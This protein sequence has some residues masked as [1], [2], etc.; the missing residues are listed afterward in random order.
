MILLS[1]LFGRLDAIVKLMRSFC[2]EE[3]KFGSIVDPNL[4]L[5]DRVIVIAMTLRESQKVPDDSL[6]LLK[7]RTVNSAGNANQATEFSATITHIR[8]ITILVHQTQVGSSKVSERVLRD[9]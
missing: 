6:Q 9:G 4:F 2:L 3:R 1:V 5:E 7:Q 8:P